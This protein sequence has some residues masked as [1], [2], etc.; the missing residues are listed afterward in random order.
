MRGTLIN[1][2]TELVVP[3]P[4]QALHPQERH[5]SNVVHVGYT[6]RAGDSLWAIGRKFGSSY[7]AIAKLNNLP[8]N[9]PLQ[10]GQNLLVQESDHPQRYAIRR[11]DSFWKMAR[12]FNVTIDQLQEWNDLSRR[13]LL[14]PGKT[15]FVSNPHN[16]AIQEI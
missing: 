14:Q 4:L 12:K 3:S 8:L 6:V 15:L 7:K 2:G 16:L 13:R 10:P 11:R 1:I 9:T 5:R